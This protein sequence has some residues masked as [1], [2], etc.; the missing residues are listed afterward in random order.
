MNFWST[1]FG[2]IISSILAG[3]IAT[4]AYVQFVNLN[5]RRTNR[6][7]YDHLKGKYEVR[8]K[9]ETKPLPNQIE[10]TKVSDNIISVTMTHIKMSDAKGDIFMNPELPNHG[11][12]YYQHEKKDA[13]GRWDIQLAPNNEI[14]NE[15]TYFSPHGVEHN[16]YVWKKIDS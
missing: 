12:G 6:K 10:I 11:T 8:E 13:W 9:R 14:Y 4:I 5:R 3:L 15:S 2:I 16:A 7:R 1:F